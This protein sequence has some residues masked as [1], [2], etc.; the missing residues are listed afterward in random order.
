MFSFTH[1]AEEKGEF[2][3]MTVRQYGVVQG[4]RKE[5]SALDEARVEAD[6]G[7]TRL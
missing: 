1:V 6:V 3:L 7:V 2:A 5:H 4:T